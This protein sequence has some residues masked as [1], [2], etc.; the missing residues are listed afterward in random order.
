MRNENYSVFMTKEYMMGPNSLRL[1]DELLSH[2]PERLSGR[3]LDLGCGMAVTSL[4]LARETEADTVFAVDLWITATDNYARIRQWGEEKRIV[5]LHSDAL[6]LPFADGFFKAIVSVDAYHYFGCREGFFAEKILPLLEPGGYALIAVPGLKEEFEN[7]I[8]A[9]MTE[10]AEDDALC[11][12][13]PQW[14]KEHI[15][16]GVEGAEVSVYESKQFDAIWNDWFESGHEY[17][18]NDKAYLERGV[19]DML[20]FVLIVVRKK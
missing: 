17:A 3:V 8:P 15:S 18:A 4:F 2:A 9:L 14:W 6:D 12:H 11:F 7:G 10:W 20:S 1:L 16:Q 19:A 13:S 5:P